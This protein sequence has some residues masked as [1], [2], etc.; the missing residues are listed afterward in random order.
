MST[1]ANCRY[2]QAH[3]NVCAASHESFERKGTQDACLAYSCFGGNDDDDF[4]MI[5]SPLADTIPSPPSPPPSDLRGLAA[6]ES[7]TF[8]LI[9]DS[10][11][12]GP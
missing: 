9:D 8:S 12:G 1:C 6:R 10:F 3:L 7:Q 11:E 2:F 5:V 4:V